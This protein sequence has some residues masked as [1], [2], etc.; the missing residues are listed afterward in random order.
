MN[1]NGILIIIAVVLIGILAVMVA[2]HN[3]EVQSPGEKV[4]SGVG[5]AVED[6]GD[7]IQDS[8]N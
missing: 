2:Q 3:R 8:A 6:L 1:R 7:Q 4:V 5:E